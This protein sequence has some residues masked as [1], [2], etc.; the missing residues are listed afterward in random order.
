MSL[1]SCP[2]RNPGRVV[3]SI[4]VQTTLLKTSPELDAAARLSN[5]FRDSAFTRNK[6]YPVHRWVPWIAGFSAEFVDDCLV[7]YPRK[8]HR[9]EVWILD[10]FA[11]VGTMLVQS[12]LGDHN[13]LGF[14]INPYAALVPRLKLKALDVIVDALTARIVAPVTSVPAP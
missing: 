1:F 3:T 14:E 13:V 4:P 5:G 10:L 11:G 2:I 12:F 7:K 8:G 9:K 6:V